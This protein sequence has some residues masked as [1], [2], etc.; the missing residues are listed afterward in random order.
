MMEEF[1][2]W[3]QGHFNPKAIRS[4]WGG[5][6]LTYLVLFVFELARPAE[7][8]PRWR[9]M[10]E[11][12]GYSLIF[13]VVGA[14][15]AFLVTSGLNSLGLKPLLDLDG[16]FPKYAIPLVLLVVNDFVYYW[17]H[18]MQHTTFLWRFHK[19]HHADQHVN[20]T[21]SLRH[22]WA[23]DPLRA[24][25]AIFPMA[26]L[27]KL[28]PVDAGLLS[29]LLANWGYALHANVR[30]DLGR[31]SAVIAGPHWHRYHHS[32]DPAHHNRNFAAFLPIWDVLFGTY[33]IGREFPRTGLGDEPSVQ[34]LP[35]VNKRGAELRPCD[36]RQA[37]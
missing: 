17:F 25:F 30:L 35:S 6:L 5:I 34:R 15:T 28:S 14:S 18:R 7:R 37:L 20:V 29:V 24:A 36:R 19:L 2:I 26:V 11:N 4:A 8:G 23:E 1:F 27:F 3:A 16:I 33:V 12:F 13:L 9:G 22:H 21:T 31:F 10:A 32:I